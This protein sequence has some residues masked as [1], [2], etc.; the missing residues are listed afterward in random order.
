MTP[1]SLSELPR[2]PAVGGTCL[3]AIGLYALAPPEAV[4]LLGLDLRAF[5]REPWRLLTSTLLHA[6]QLRSDDPFPG[7]FHVGFNVY[8]L[9]TLGAPIE[10]RLGHL[11][12]LGLLV[13]FALAGS[14]LEYAMSGSAVG[15]S[16]VVYGLVAMLAVLGR[17]SPRWSGLLDRRALNFFG[18]W[19]VLCVAMTITDL[20]PVANFAH[21]GGAS[22]GA[23]LGWA[24]VERGPRRAGAISTLVASLALFSAGATVLRPTVN[25]SARAGLDAMVLAAEAERAGDLAAA[26]ALAERGTNYHRAPAEHWAYLARLYYLSDRIDDAHRALREAVLRDPEHALYRSALAEIEEML[27]PT[28]H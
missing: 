9:W 23:L 5:G 18:F 6:S 27:A 16:G 20:V 12:T 25:F 19:F 3:L 8:W 1:A 22:A 21:A 7:L 10:A 11:R 17:R 2:F 24:M 28:P 14:L 15:L 4:E 13:L 26:V